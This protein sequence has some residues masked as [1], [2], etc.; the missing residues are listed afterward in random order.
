[1]EELKLVINVGGDTIEERAAGLQEVMEQLRWVFFNA[2]SPNMIEKLYRESEDGPYF[3]YSE[4][5]NVNKGKCGYM[6][7]LENEILD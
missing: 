2:G 7:T 1:M 4:D 3:Q 6:V 5:G